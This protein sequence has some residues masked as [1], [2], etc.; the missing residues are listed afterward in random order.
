MASPS[1]GNAHGR[2]TGVHV[3]TG[4]SVS[5]AG[6]RGPPATAAIHA[7]HQIDAL[8][9]VPLA[10]LIQHLDIAV[11]TILG[12]LGNW[13]AYCLDST[14]IQFVGEFGGC[15]I[16]IGAQFFSGALK[17]CGKLVSIVFNSHGRCLLPDVT[18]PCDT[19]N[20]LR[21]S[22]TSAQTSVL[23]VLPAFGL[24]PGVSKG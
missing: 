7:S 15:V 24:A 9:L 10:C 6:H 3:I 8:L 5:S 14:S 21:P 1:I 13:V 23:A 12:P 20:L 2:H 16:P 19:Y 4:A 18:I 22:L 17:G 11:I